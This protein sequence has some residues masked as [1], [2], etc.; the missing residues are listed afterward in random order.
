MH[1]LEFTIVNLYYII[2]I[3]YHINMIVIAK[4]L[5]GMHSIKWTEPTQIFLIDY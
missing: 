2:V 1:K 3:M 5:F 4:L